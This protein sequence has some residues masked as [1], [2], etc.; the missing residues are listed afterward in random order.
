MALIDLA[1]ECEAAPARDEH[2]LLFQ[3]YVL[4]FGGPECIPID[5][6]PGYKSPRW[7]RFHA[8]LKAGAYESAAFSLVPEGWSVQVGR[9]WRC[10]IKEGKAWAS[11]M[12]RQYGPPDISADSENAATPALALCAA[13]LRARAASVDRSP[14]GEDR[15]GLHA[16]HE[17][18]V[19]KAIAQILFETPHD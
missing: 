6:W 3:A 1:A 5:H 18:A 15:N 7:D 4:V 9:G 8:M 11:V 14:K 13:A 16:E 19:P 17:S 2:D 12:D 10:D